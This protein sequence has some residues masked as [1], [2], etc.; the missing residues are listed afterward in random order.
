MSLPTNGQLC[1][2]I[3]ELSSTS[4]LLPPPASYKNS[5]V[6]SRVSANTPAHS[7]ALVQRCSAASGFHYSALLLQLHP[8]NSFH[9]QNKNLG[10]SEITWTCATGHRA[11]IS[12]SSEDALSQVT[13]SF[14][15]LDSHWE[16]PASPELFQV[17][18]SHCCSFLLYFAE[19][20]YCGLY[21][22]G[23]MGS[24]LVSCFA[25]CS[26]EQPFT[27]HPNQVTTENDR[28]GSSHNWVFAQV[29]LGF[30]AQEPSS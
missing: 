20:Q 10:S 28:L 18:K 24:L 15:C 3:D 11:R 8:G 16:P 27:F 14:S 17:W 19:A 23:V 30:G 5:M 7:R 12:P 25:M 29:F 26:S 2:I 21:E 22:G 6:F 13:I 1:D 9:I 4:H